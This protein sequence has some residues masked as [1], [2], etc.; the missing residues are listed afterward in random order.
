[1][2]LVTAEALRR[3]RVVA[4]DPMA[5]PQVSGATAARP[6]PGA[7]AAQ[8]QV[9]L[10]ELGAAGPQER[11]ACPE[12]G[13]EEVQEWAVLERAVLERAVLEW[14]APPPRPEA[15]VEVL[16]RAAPAGAPGA[17]L[18]GAG[19]RRAALAAKPVRRQHR[20]PNRG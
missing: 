20:Y 7:A 16:A 4:A 14:A 3:V 6:E 11:V 1:M 18:E 5:A 10:P 13:A 19:V 8:G 9:A 17:R 2:P 12:P 15:P